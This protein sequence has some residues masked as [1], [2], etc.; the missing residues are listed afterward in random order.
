MVRQRKA[1]PVAGAQETQREKAE[2]S[3]HIRRP[4]RSPYAN[5]TY[6]FPPSP[7]RLTG[8][9][10]GAEASCTSGLC[11]RENNPNSQS[12]NATLSPAPRYGSFLWFVILFAFNSENTVPTLFSSDA[13]ISLV[14]AGLQSIP[15]LTG[16]HAT[17]F[18]FAIYTGDLVSHDP[19]HQLSRLVYMLLDLIYLPLI[20]LSRRDYVQYTEVC[21]S[22]IEL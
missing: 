8:F 15:A 10:N 11:C 18:D 16:T 5:P 7:H 21:W 14:L 4:P 1:L 22:R 19:D 17:G 12:P 2:G 9:S 6:I 3:T 13:P 20:E